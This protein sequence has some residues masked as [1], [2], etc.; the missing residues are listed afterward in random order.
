[1]AR[2]SR[3]LCVVIDPG[4]V[5]YHA[6]TIAQ[7]ISLDGRISTRGWDVNKLCAKT[8]QSAA[9]HVL[10]CE[11]LR[12]GPR[13]NRESGVVAMVCLT[14][15]AMRSPHH[16][17]TLAASGL[18]GD[19]AFV[20]TQAHA[21]YAT[22]F[23]Y[24]RYFCRVTNGA[25]RAWILVPKGCWRK[26]CR[27]ALTG[28]RGREMRGENGRQNQP[29]SARDTGTAGVI[30]VETTS[31][32][33]VVGPAGLEPATLCLEG[34]CSIQLSYE[35]KSFH[36]NTLPHAAVLIRRCNKGAVR[37]RTSHPHLIAAAN[38]LAKCLH[39]QG[40]RFRHTLS[41]VLERCRR[42]RMP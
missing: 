4:S 7:Q 32:G 14:R 34:R 41:I 16:K 36:F 39:R 1:M 28:R 31:C 40:K 26:R 13:R 38:L 8:N 22:R 35:P 20:R 17:L 5:A 19:E 23:A 25:V 30:V 33:E 9:R 15:L 42:A 21:Y 10:A 27:E 11:Y 18:L 29:H 6:M 24:L 2:R 12:P 3:C 37:F